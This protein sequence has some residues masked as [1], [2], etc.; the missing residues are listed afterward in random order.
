MDVFNTVSDDEGVKGIDE[1][2]DAIFSESRSGEKAF[3]SG[4]NNLSFLMAD[5]YIKIYNYPALNEVND[6]ALSMLLSY[7]PIRAEQ[8]NYHLFFMYCM[9]VGGLI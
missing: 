9:T 2:V 3:H 5:L 1:L 6:F 7:Q 4:P 8:K